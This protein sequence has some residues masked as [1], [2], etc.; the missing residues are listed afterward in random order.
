MVTRHYNMEVF[1]FILTQLLVNCIQVYC[2]LT[3]R[4]P[5]LNPI[6]RVDRS[7]RDRAKSFLREGTAGRRSLLADIYEQEQGTKGKVT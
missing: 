3:S 2:I 7:I 6:N 4:L 1:I 5:L